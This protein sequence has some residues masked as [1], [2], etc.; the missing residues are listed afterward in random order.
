LESPAA[1]SAGGVYGDNHGAFKIATLA[2]NPTHGLVGAATIDS[3]KRAAA[4][5]HLPGSG[6]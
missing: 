3:T 2:F 5:V 6:Q 1:K 4:A